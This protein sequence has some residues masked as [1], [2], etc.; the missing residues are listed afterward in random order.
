MSEIDFHPRLNV[1]VA[2][3]D[4]VFRSLVVARLLHLDCQFFE[5]ADGSEAWLVTRTHKLDLAIVDFEM[6]GLDGIALIRCLRG[7]PDTRHIPI[8]M[9]TSHSNSVAMQAALEAGASSFLSKPVNWSL[10]QRHIGHLQQLSRNT[11]QTLAMLEQ[12]GAINTQKDELVAQLL[13]SLRQNIQRAAGNGPPATMAAS[14][15]K[16][17]SA[18]EAAYQRCVALMHT[19]RSTSEASGEVSRSA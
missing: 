13:T 1:L 11:A 4:P 18:F 12:M 9:C 16:D 8:V 19:T 14:L 6:P 15:M 7:H 5:A 17:L 10:F 2:D 3:D